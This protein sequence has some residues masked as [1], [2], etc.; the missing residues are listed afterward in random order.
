MLER[1]WLVALSLGLSGC[2]AESPQP[3][4]PPAAT[5]R[6]SAPDAPSKPTVI[7]VPSA[8][9]AAQAPEQAPVDAPPGTS[10]ELVR[11]I[12]A[13]LAAANAGDQ[14]AQQA[15]STSECWA[16]ECSSFAGQA[17]K[18]FR[19]E[20]RPTL[21]RRD[22]HALAVVD[23]ICDGSRKCDLVYLLFEFTPSLSWVVVDVTEDGKRADAWVTPAGY[24]EPKMAPNVPP[25]APPPTQPPGPAPP[26]PPKGTA[27][28][29]QLDKDTTAP[30]N[31]ARV[32][33]GLR[34]GFRACYLAALALD[35]QAAGELK[36]E[37]DVAPSGEVADASVKPVSGTLPRSLIQCVTRRV[38]AAKFEAPLSD[39]ATLR[40]PVTFS[41]AAGGKK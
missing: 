6:T 37:I 12:D 33:A 8:P 20:R 13:Y 2:A 15:G 24:V 28:I 39:D 14:T 9:P 22:N 36:I 29:G 27:S 5:A 40:F 11:A 23:I 26:A 16:K 30:A 21:R 3:R 35:A 7:L 34:A 4:P 18:K 19:A 31:S 10:P 32:V 41:P 1:L 25:G 17:G 38:R